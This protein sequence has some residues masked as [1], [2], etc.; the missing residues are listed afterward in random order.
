[1]FSVFIHT[2][3]KLHEVPINALIPTQSSSRNDN[4][5][6]R[7][8]YANCRVHIKLMWGECYSRP[9]TL[10]EQILHCPEILF[11][12]NQI[13]VCLPKPHAAISVVVPNKAGNTPMFIRGKTDKQ[14]W[15]SHTVECETMKDF[16]VNINDPKYP[17]QS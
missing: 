4:T 6:G 7:W 10:A 5:K 1:M 2:E 15:C 11:L 16:Y 17:R 12:G 13:S 9:V 3:F 14:R 8:V